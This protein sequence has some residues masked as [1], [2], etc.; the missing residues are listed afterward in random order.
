MTRSGCWPRRSG[1]ST[2]ASSGS[3][4]SRYAEENGTFGL[5]TM[6]RKHVTVTGDLVVFDYIAKSGKQRVQSVV[7]DER[8]Q[9]RRRAAQARRPEQGAARLQGPHRL[10][11]HH[12]RRHQRLPARGDRRRGERQGLPHLAR[13]GADGRRA[14]G[15]DAGTDLGERAQA[16][17][18]PRGQGGRRVPRQHPRG[19]PVVLHRPAGHRPVRRRRDH[20]GRRS[21]GSGRTPTSASRPPTAWSRQRCC[22]CCAGRPRPP[23]GDGPPRPPRPPDRRQ[24]SSA[25]SSDSDASTRSPHRRVGQV[26]AG[27]G[28]HL[29]QRLVRAVAAPG[30]HPDR[31]ARHRHPAAEHDAGHHPLVHRLGQ[32]AGIGEREAHRRTGAGRPGRPRAAAARRHH[33]ACTTSVQGVRRSPASSARSV[34]TTQPPPRS[35]AGGDHPL[36]RLERQRRTHVV[37][38]AL[39]GVGTSREGGYGPAAVGQVPR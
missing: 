30:H 4:A 13:D 27:V 14:R 11:R 36:P 17:R 28:H 15:L 38:Q 21:S 5:A 16:G 1:C 8:P 33:W 29:P 10:A 18:D 31:P 3:A 37:G 6:R 20:R 25:R 7:D 34:A 9:G 12:Q 23:V 32:P 2:S 24:P 19:L 35:R 39:G 26:D 22:G